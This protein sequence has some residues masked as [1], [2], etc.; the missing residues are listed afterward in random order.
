MGKLKKILSKHSGRDAQGH[1][2]VR[3][4]GG[5]QKRYLRIIDFARNKRGMSAQVEGIEYDPNRTARVALLLYKDG[6]R[7]YIL[8][9]EGLKVGDIVEAGE[10]ASLRP[11]NSLPLGLIPVGTNVH[12]LEMRIGR[13]GQVVRGAGSFAVV[14]GREEKYVLIK[15][16]SGEIR[17]FPKEAY[18]TIGQVGRVE[19]EKLGLAGRMRRLGVRPRVRGTA[20]HPA[21]HPHGGGEGRSGEGMPP[22]TPWGKPARGVK[23]RNPRKNSSKLIVKRRRIGYGSK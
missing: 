16:P 17:R 19:S 13:G 10:M 1:V 3:H 15:L 9:P 7:R 6:Q 2:A 12:N 11:G 5:R 4:Q 8:S 14:F 21:A 20:M 18:A 22:K 23:T